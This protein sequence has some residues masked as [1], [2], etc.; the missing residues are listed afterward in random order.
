MTAWMKDASQSERPSFGFVRPGKAVAR[1]A[2]P[3]VV[4]IVIAILAFPS[5][6][7]WNPLGL[8]YA[9]PTR[10]AKVKQ[11]ARRD[12][13]Y[14]VSDCQ[15]PEKTDSVAL[16]V[17]EDS[18]KLSQIL[19]MNCIAAT[20]PETVKVTYVKKG[21]NLE[22]TVLLRS[23]MQSDCTCPIGIEGTISNLAKG[24]YRISFV[25]DSKLGRSEDDKA[26]RKV[27]GTKDFS[28]ER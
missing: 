22:V 7:Q 1:V 14:A 4:A 18:V 2:L 28:I 15:G 3:T 8:A 25:F 5:T 27:L 13:V 24:D 23:E 26:T 6:W 12:F 21:H 20:H 10:A 9:A 11:Q 17:S 16:E 19:T